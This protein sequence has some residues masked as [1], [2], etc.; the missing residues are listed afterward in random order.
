MPEKR[1]YG[2]PEFRDKVIRR[3]ETAYADIQITRST[4]PL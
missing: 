1:K 4:A 3:L 2:V